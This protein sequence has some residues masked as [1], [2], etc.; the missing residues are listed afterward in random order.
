MD[1]GAGRYWGDDGADDELDPWDPW[2][3]ENLWR[4]QAGLTMETQAAG[5]T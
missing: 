3:L 5:V 4:P 2:P 1:F